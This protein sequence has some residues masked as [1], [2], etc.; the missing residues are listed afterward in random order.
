MS[1]EGG[2][3]EGSHR[4]THDWTRDCWCCQHQRKYILNGN[5]RDRCSGKVIFW[6][7]RLNGISSLKSHNNRE[8]VVVEKE[9]KIF[10]SSYEMRIIHHFSGED[11][12]G[13]LWKNEKCFI[14]FRERFCAFVEF[15]HNKS[16]LEEC[17]WNM[18]M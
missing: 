1:G 15:R 13:L 8:G 6:R 17:W 14:L 5:L 4:W 16:S 7:S 2:A 12:K 18:G 9:K 11:F 10:Q 3:K